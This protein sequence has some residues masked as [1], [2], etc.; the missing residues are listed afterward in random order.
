[1]GMVGR[2][3]RSHSRK[4]KSE[5]EISR[6]AG[7]SRNT[8]SKWLDGDVNGPPRYRR[9]EQRGKLTVFHEAL[10]Q[11][12][13]ADAPRPRHERRTAKALYSEVRAAGFGGGYIRVTDFVRA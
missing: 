12:L 3:R 6:M 1:M 11:A 9:C 5:R 7:L 2:I 8:G 10:K 13:K 4:N